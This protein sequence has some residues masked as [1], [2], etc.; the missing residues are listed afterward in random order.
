MANIL[1]ES[2]WPKAKEALLDGP[3]LAGP[4]NEYKRKT[5]ETM[6]E[7]TRKALMENAAVTSTTN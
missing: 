1:S 6:L 7:S 3:D 5:M 4:K 2:L